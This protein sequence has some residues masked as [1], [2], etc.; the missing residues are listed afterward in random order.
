VRFAVAPDGKADRV[1]IENLN[2]HGQ[3]TFSR[4]E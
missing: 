2:V 1:L 3:G 4:V